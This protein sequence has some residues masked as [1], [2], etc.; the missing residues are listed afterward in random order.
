MHPIVYTAIYNNMAT[1]N[2]LA[3]CN[4]IAILTKPEDLLKTGVL[5]IKLLYPNSN[6]SGLQLGIRNLGFSTTDWVSLGNHHYRLQITGYL[7]G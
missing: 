3:I 1:I 2:Q 7:G 6:V 4:S 5:D